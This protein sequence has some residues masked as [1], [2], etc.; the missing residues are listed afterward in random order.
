[1]AGGTWQSTSLLGHSQHTK[2]LSAGSEE[3]FSML[4]SLT[5]G[6]FGF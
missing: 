1:L 6:K 5:G 4:S 2:Q 3:L